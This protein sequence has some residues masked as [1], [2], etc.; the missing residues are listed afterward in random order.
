MNISG[1]HFISSQTKL[2]LLIR[3]K[4]HRAIQLLSEELET[5]IF[6]YK[7]NGVSQH[8][9]ELETQSYNHVPLKRSIEKIMLLR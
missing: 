2:L 4:I 6:Y 3:T 5:I 7:L 8:H 9:Y 1:I